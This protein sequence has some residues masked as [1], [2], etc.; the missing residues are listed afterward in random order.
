MPG[1]LSRLSPARAWRMLSGV[2]HTSA[3][4]QRGGEASP[5]HCIAPCPRSPA[6]RHGASCPPARA[7]SLIVREEQPSKG[8][9]LLEAKCQSLALTQSFSN[10]VKLWQGL[11]AIFKS[12]YSHEILRPFKPSSSVSASKGIQGGPSSDPLSPGETLQKI[13]IRAGTEGPYYSRRVALLQSAEGWC[14]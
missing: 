9:L 7:A 1:M 10:C 4:G 3:Q 5:M 6:G 8:S 2:G 13:S 11:R 12:F 14:R